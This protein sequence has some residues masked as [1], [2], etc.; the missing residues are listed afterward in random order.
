M[1]W[2]DGR[3]DPAQPARSLRDLELVPWW[4]AGSPA[5]VVESFFSSRRYPR[6]VASASSASP[7]RGRLL[8]CLPHRQ[9]VDG[10]PEAQS[11]GFFDVNNTPP[12]ECWVAYETPT[13]GSWDLLLAWVP[14]LLVPFADAGVQ[15]CCD[16]SLEWI[17]APEAFR[18]PALRVCLAAWRE[19]ARVVASSPW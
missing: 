4:F 14:E 10:A 9:L 6:V 12:W 7:P 5:A 19:T 17:D 11:S 3:A 2:C 1:R 8:A 15:V 16:E 13:D 18:V